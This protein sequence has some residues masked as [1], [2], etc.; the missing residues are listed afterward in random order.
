MSAQLTVTAVGVVCL[1]VVGLA[2]AV[3][4][5]SPG[6]FPSSELRLIANA[7]TSDLPPHSLEWGISS[8]SAYNVPGW[9]FHGAT[10]NLYSDAYLIGGVGYHVYDQTIQLPSGAV[11]VGLTLYYYDGD[12]TGDSTF[13][14]FRWT[15][16]TTTGFSATS[17]FVD[18][19]SGSSGYQG[20][21]RA[22]LAPETV[23]NVDP[24][25]GSVSMYRLQWTANVFGFDEYQRFGGVVV[26]YRLQVSPAP[27][28]ATFSDVPTG[29]WAFRHIEALAASGISAGCGGGNYCPESYVKRSEMAVYLAKALG[30]HW[31]DG[32]AL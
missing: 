12:A 23:H 29:Y 17:I 8:P 3:A 9:T 16:T 14:V 4:A 13:E 6:V 7:A 11:V 21:Y 5:Q 2:P 10:V 20:G 22:L 31:P 15:G 25:S 28:T 18:T 26:W 1:I 30:L 32:S 19:S 24:M 27:A